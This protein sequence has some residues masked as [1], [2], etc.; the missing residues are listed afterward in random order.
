MSKQRDIPES[1][2]WG[3]IG[4]LRFEK[5]QIIVVDAVE[6]ARSV[7]TRWIDS[8]D[9]NQHIIRKGN[10]TAQRY[11]DK[12]LK[13]HARPHTDCLMENF[14]EAETIQRMVWSAYLFDLNPV[15]HIWTH[16]DDA[17]LQ[18]QGLLLLSKTSRSHFVQ[19][20]RVFPKVSS[21][22]C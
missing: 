1:M 21:H 16:S 20:G 3:I 18:G 15:Q 13:H 2:A 17:L 11:A 10:F 19:S 8:I 5:T 14:L 7:I 22:P 9:W 12:I 4:R 6:V